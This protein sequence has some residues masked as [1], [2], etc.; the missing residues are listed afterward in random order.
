MN[1]FINASPMMTQY[2][3]QC[4]KRENLTAS[5]L[6]RNV[7]TRSPVRHLV[8]AV[9]CVREERRLV[10]LLT[11]CCDWDLL[12][13]L[14]LVFDCVRLLDVPKVSCA[15]GG[16]PWASKEIVNSFCAPI[17]YLRKIFP[18]SRSDPLCSIYYHIPLP[19]LLPTYPSSV[20]YT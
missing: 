8:S 15:N 7:G 14:L 12:A 13:F 10:P 18:C 17:S 20:A 2:S 3:V 1:L 11:S 5:C 19:Y 16:H 6:T 4:I 9:I